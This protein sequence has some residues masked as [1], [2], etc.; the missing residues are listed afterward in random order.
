MAKSRPPKRKRYRPPASPMGHPVGRAV[1]KRD[2]RSRLTT[3]RIH[4]LQLQDGED[5][6]D[7]LAEAAWL[8]G[9]GT[10]VCVTVEGVGSHRTRRL[11][12]TLRGMV[13]L[14]L[15]GYRWKEHQRMPVDAALA[16]SHALIFAHDAVAAEHMPG[17]NYLEARIRSRE[18]QATDVAGAELYTTA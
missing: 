9:L 3:L 11:H 5:C 14:C 6:A 13:Q 2:V 7:V 18:V 1:L 16:E 8:V 12:G 4:L 10:E 15:E 17:A